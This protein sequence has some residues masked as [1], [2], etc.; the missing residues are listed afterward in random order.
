MRQGTVI[1]MHLTLFV[2][3]LIWPDRD[4]PKAFDFP[5][6][7]AL[8]RFLFLAERT[9]TALAPADSWE[10]VLANTFG[11]HQDMPPLGALRLLGESHQNN[12]STYGHALLCADPVN[13]DFMQHALVLSQPD[14][15]Q[16][17]A[18]EAHR[19][20][21]SLNA[22]FADEGRFIFVNTTNYWYFIPTNADKQIPNLAA[23]SRF[24][25]RRIDA[26]ESRHV[27]GSDGLHW[28][29]RIQMCLND[30]PVNEARQMQGL[31]PINSV[32]PWGNG[33]LAPNPGST[34]APFDQASGSNA[35]LRGLCEW[36]GTAHVS[37]LPSGTN[38]LLLE[39][40]LAEAIAQ[41]NLD[42]WQQTINKL[43]QESLSPA[44][45]ALARR[46]LNRLTL[47]TVDA[48]QTHQWTLNA[49][50]KALRPGFIQRFL[51]RDRAHPSL[52]SLI[53]TW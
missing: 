44:L 48:H 15:T 37:S 28:L 20:I 1:S 32:W 38:A 8:A 51:G 27:L 46:E 40:G 5:H 36:T 49:D 25:G 39:T 43:T 35:L 9:S 19:L 12:Q 3:D 53:G 50:H 6:A 17:N 7:D 4:D 10:S 16:L 33:S 47:I 41:D 30:H 52:G 45:G 24:V 42:V 11:L 29:N 23:C 18:D 21:D 14:A 22:E 34:L 26:N 31:P 2:P 13:L